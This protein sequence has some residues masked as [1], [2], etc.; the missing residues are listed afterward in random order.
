MGARQGALPGGIGD[1]V[2]RM[3]RDIAGRRRPSQRSR[4][5]MDHIRHM[6][7]VPGQPGTGAMSCAAVKHHRKA[8]TAFAAKGRPVRTES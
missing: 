7:P 3:A 4:Y 6:P 2:R 8:P 5:R 1:G